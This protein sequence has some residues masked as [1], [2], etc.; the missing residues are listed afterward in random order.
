VLT[1][2]QN[3]FRL[4]SYDVQNSHKDTSR[5]IKTFYFKISVQEII[6]YL[7]TPVDRYRHSMGTKHMYRHK[8]RQMNVQIIGL[9]YL[10]EM[11]HCMYGI[12]VLIA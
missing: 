4:L 2:S 10:H 11:V 3:T 5:R 9:I 7:Y 8:D 1:G 12:C 6:I